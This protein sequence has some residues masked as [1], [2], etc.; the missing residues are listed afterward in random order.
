MLHYCAAGL[1][2]FATLFHSIMGEKMLIKPILAVDDPAI[3]HPMTQGIIKFGW[4]SSSGF[5]LVTALALILP[6]T[7]RPLEWAIGG[8][9]LVLGLTNMAMM[10]GKHPG[11]YLLSLI[12]ITILGGLFLA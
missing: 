6:G 4:H 2:V 7:P 8:L 11:G 12:G 3:Q 5:F 1:I 10:Q 9:W